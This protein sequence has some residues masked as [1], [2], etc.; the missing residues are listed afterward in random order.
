MIIISCSYQF[1][2]DRRELD[3]FFF[4]KNIHV[5]YK[6]IEAKICEILRI[7]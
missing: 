6:N 4:Y 2:Q 5:F 3:S 1:E 7:F